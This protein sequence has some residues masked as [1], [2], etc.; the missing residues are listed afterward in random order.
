MTDMSE[1]FNGAATFNSDIGSWDTSN[2]TTMNSMFAFASSFN[3]GGN[4][5][6][7]LWN[8][9]NVRYMSSMFYQATVFNQDIHS[10]DASYA[11]APWNNQIASFRVASALSNANTPSAI[12]ARGE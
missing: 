8:T 5:S 10:W 9:T 4:S 1:M 2:V 3:N 6:I 12:F 11:A 7:G